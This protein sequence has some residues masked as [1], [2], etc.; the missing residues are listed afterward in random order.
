MARGQAY[1]ASYTPTNTSALRVYAHATGIP[2]GG[3]AVK[4]I[5]WGEDETAGAW[6]LVQ[7]QWGELWGEKGLFRIVRG[8]NECGIED[9]VTAGTV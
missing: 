4:L 9:D 7:N 2:L 1:V 6:W 8:S 5:G 3:H